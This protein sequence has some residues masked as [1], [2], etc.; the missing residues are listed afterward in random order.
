MQPETKAVHA[1]EHLPVAPRPLM[2]PIYQSSVFL[3][4]D[5]QRAA[6]VNA[7][8]AEGYSY[9]RIGNPNA[10]MFGQAV[11]ALE[12]AEAGAVAASGMAAILSALLAL[13]QGGEVAMAEEVYG[14]SVALAR[15]FLEPLGVR[16]HSFDAHDPGSLPRGISVAL[17]E[18]ISNPLVRVNDV[19]AL[20]EAAHRQG[21]RLV[22]DNTFA[23]PAL[24]HP[25]RHGADLV[26]HSATKF[27]SGHGD[28]VLGA[29][30]G[31]RELV[32]RAQTA[33][34]TFG[35]TPDP[36]AAWLGLLGLRTFSV[37]MQQAIENAAC[38]ARFLAQHPA[39]RR[40]HHPSLASNPY[41]GLAE[42]QF[43]GRGPAILAFDLA[44]LAA[45]SRFVD[46]LTLIQYA[47]S[48]GDVATTILH[49]ATTSHRQLAA[50]EL[51]HLGITPGTIR[52]SLGIEAA[53]DLIAELDH[54]LA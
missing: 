21:A 54:A 24:F 53:E 35:G 9:S 12:E 47:P 45:A 5:L 18:T 13:R 29:V 22:I 37:R 41:H 26:V 3:F 49:P 27:L 50:S 32:G 6:D 30:V 17:A 28:V 51:E 34:T 8:T 43:S 46:R 33:L 7:G 11:A 23:T 38:V 48:L 36:F 2:A 52:L 31:S 19:E 14:G 39:V 15:G 20:S 4:D 44:D 16:C 25:L 40:V 42:R 1:G 10:D